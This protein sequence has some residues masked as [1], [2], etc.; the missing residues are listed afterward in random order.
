MEHSCCCSTSGYKSPKDAING[1]KEKVVFLPC[2]I[3]EK[4][5]YLASVDVDP[6]SPTY[7]RMYKS[8]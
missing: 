6:S 8:C 5:D 4:V 3:P 1:P 2:I 7:S